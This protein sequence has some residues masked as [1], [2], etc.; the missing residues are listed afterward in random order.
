[1][2]RPKLPRSS[3]HL[4]PSDPLELLDEPLRMLAAL[5]CEGKELAVIAFKLCVVELRLV[6]ENFDVDSCATLRA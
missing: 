5:A 6:G 1:M 2:P 4:N 3:A